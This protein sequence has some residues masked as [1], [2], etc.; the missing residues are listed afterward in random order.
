[1]RRRELLVGPMHQC[2]VVALILLVGSARTCRAP[3]DACPLGAS[4]SAASLSRTSRRVA[5]RQRHMPSVTT[6]GYD[7]EPRPRHH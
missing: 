4:A 2:S 7:G 1:M 3:S 6:A 5:L